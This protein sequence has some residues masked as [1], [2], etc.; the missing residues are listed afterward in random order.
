VAERL[1]PETQCPSGAIRHW[2]WDQ[3]FN[4]SALSVIPLQTEDCCDTRTVYPSNKNK[5]NQTNDAD[6]LRQR[7]KRGVKRRR[8]SSKITATRSGFRAK[9]TH[10][11]IWISRKIRIDG[12]S[13][14]YKPPFS[15][16]DI[17][18]NQIRPWIPNKT[19]RCELSEPL[20]HTRQKRRPGG[21]TLR[22]SCGNCERLALRSQRPRCGKHS[23]TPPL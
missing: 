15:N 21:E 7:H 19:V 11:R 20:Q 16:L 12:G 6:P 2:V 14:E 10:T 5:N 17:P 9:S 23:R 18:Q 1:A 8:F 4:R 13:A 3:G 22:L